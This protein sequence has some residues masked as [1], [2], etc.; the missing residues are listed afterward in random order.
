MRQCY[1]YRGTVSGK[2][3]KHPVPTSGIP[4]VPAYHRTND[5]PPGS[6]GYGAGEESSRVP[7]QKGLFG[8]EYNL[9]SFGSRGSPVPRRLRSTQHGSGLSLQRPC[10]PDPLQ[11]RPGEGFYLCGSSSLL[12]TLLFSHRPR[13]HHPVRS[14]DARPQ[15]ARRTPTGAETLWRISPPCIR[16]DNTSQSCFLSHIRTRSWHYGSRLR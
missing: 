13:R 7:S 9:S 11:N 10:P 14:E 5:D 6:D 1:R 4:H 3:R 15:E 8:P 16:E 2:E 12:L